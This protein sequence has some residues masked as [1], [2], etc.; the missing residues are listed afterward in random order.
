MGLLA[1]PAAGQ[2]SCPNGENYSPCTCTSASEGYTVTCSSVALTE[3]YNIFRRTTAADLYNLRITIASAD[4]N[5]VIPAALINNHRVSYNLAITCPT[6]GLLKLDTAAFLSVNPTVFT[7]SNCDLRQLSFEFMNGFNNLAAIQL[8][9][10]LNI[11]SASW[12]TLPLLQDLVYLKINY[13]TGMNQ[14]TNFP[15][16]AGLAWLDLSYNDIQDG[17]MSNIL[18]W[19]LGSS[20]DTMQFIE[21]AYN[22]L[23]SIPSQIASFPN[24]EDLIINNQNPASMRTITARSIRTNADIGFVNIKSNGITT[25]QCG[26]FEG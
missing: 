22:S 9:T 24:W 20:A 13:G 25:I 11:N 12:S 23:T 8:L 26:A 4:A 2:A 19:I 18:N 6:N 3:I 10:D 1:G 16:L 7:A 14:W 5:S 21:I 15:R 17:P